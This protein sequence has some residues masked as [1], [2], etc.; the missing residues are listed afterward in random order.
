MIY[1]ANYISD[2]CLCGD[3]FKTHQKFYEHAMK[4]SKHTAY[5]EMT[6]MT[7]L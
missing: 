2:I 3:K 1:P 5:R 6:G 4:C 7:K